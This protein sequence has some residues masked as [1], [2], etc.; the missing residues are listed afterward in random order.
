M[1]K[2]RDYYGRGLLKFLSK[3]TSRIMKLTAFLSMLTVLNLF[4]AET[5]SQLTK[6]TLKLEDVRISD[7]LKEIENQ[8]EFF[9]LYSPKLINVESK[10]NITAENETIK[11]ILSNIF[12]E[13]VKFAVYDR[14]IIL[15]PTEQSGILSA[16]QQQLKIS[17]T[18]TDENGNPLAGVTVQVKNTLIGVLTDASG[19]YSIDNV[20]SDATL[21]FSFVGMATQ[22]ITTEG[23]V[24]IDV[25]LKEE[26]IGLEEV[27]VVGYGTQKKATL[28]GSIVSAG[29]AQ[30]VKS[31]ATNV[32]HNLMGILPGLSAITSGGEPGN[33]AAVLRIRG[34]NT[35][36][37]NS[38]LIVIDGT[39]NRDLKLLESSD[40]ESITVL[41]DASAAIY[42]SQSANGVILVTTRRGGIGKPKISINMNGGISQPTRIPE[43]ADAATYATMLNEIAYYYTPANGRNQRYSE[44]DITAF[45][46]G[47]DPWGHPNTDWFKEV[48]KS[49]SGQNHENVSINGGTEN[50]KY[51]VSM[52]AKFQDAFY[53]NSAAYYNQYNIRSNID[54][55][56]SKNISISLDI[57]GTQSTR[58]GQ[59][60]SEGTLWRSIMHMYPTLN[61]HWPDGKPA[62]GIEEGMNPTVVVTPAT[63]YQDDKNY[64]FTTNLRTNITIPWVNGLSITGNAAIDKSVGFYRQ[65]RKP[66]YLY[67]WNGL[68]DHITTPVKSGLEAPDLR[69]TFNGGQYMSINGYIT[70]EKLIAGRHALKIMAGTERRN[71]RYD[72]FTA[73]RK[74]FISSTIDQLFAGASDKYMSN[75]G[76]ASQNAYLSYFGRINYDFN[77]K[78]LLEF[79]WREDG[80]YKFP[81]DKRF[82]FFPGISAGWIISEE[83]FWKNNISFINNLK[84]RASWGQ[85]GND[86]IADYQYL[87]T[88]GFNS[89]RT[90]VFNGVD[91]KLLVETQI[92]NPNVTWEVANQTN[93]GFDA[94][95]F[96][97]K[98]SVSVE[99]FRN[100]RSKILIQRNASIPASSGLT[101]P[102]ENIGKVQ[103]NG[104]EAVIGYHGNAGSFDYNLTLNGSYSRNKIDF[105]DE[106]PGVPDYQKSTG[107]PI[108]AELYYQAIGI[109]KDE[110]SLDAYPH[111]GGAGPGDIIFED[112]NDD[113]V[114]NSL[115]M[116]RSDKTT[117]PTFLGG[118]SISLRYKEFDLSMLIQG[119]AGAQKLVQGESGE[120][121]N[122][123][124]DFAANRWTPENNNASYPRAY[125]RGDRYWILN[126]STF[127]LRNTAYIRLKNFELG[128]FLPS[129]VN[130]ALGIE[131]LRFYVNGFNLFTIDKAKIIDPEAAEG[132][133]QSY[134]LQR[135]INAGF[136]LTF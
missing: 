121:G 60:T 110:A 129:G 71:G 128:Y 93:I 32:T 63:G 95:L 37:N 120:I 8:S 18:V 87:A 2:L 98:L 125:S 79:V 70:Y 4:A 49:W 11:D 65:F 16:F 19:K 57:T 101:L 102:P 103:N 88:Y 83:N 126:P 73:Y 58:N 35:L 118:V 42:G 94:L 45:A 104:F 100:L 21:I 10:V 81:S 117:L 41:K 133:G 82:G 14:Q 61:A 119:A 92:P 132:R 80:S 29:G 134:P 39:P 76:T 105:W 9:F 66:W 90:Y 127:W 130:T 44:A 86:R 36:G 33:D 116:V 124:E 30:L 106:T 84:I 5:Y 43:M 112:V 28:T 13:K 59:Y 12:D 23:R 56:I 17:G 67:S 108:G 74:N 131:R 52:G 38:P 48:L 89:S 7:A 77:R 122:Y 115:D 113:G 24:L 72:Q 123:F 25:V 85:T 96:K 47:S 51:Y 34:L 69:E 1:K 109:F 15:T 107:M 54:G 46:D 75:D 27:V 26:A 111:W 97:D 68:P 22:E 31:P 40:I 3:K 136:T 135:V 20:P 99:Y 91:N 50:L 64:V 6:L 53:K 114:I 62:L 78:Y 55:R